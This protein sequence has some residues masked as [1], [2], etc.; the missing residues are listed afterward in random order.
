M[1]SNNIEINKKTYILEDKVLGEGA[2]GVVYKARDRNGD[3]VA[4]KKIPKNKFLVE[5]KTFLEFFKDDCDVIVCFKDFEEKTDYVY[6]VME[7]IEGEELNSSHVKDIGI[8]KLFKTLVNILNK[9][10]KKDIYHLDIKPANILVNKKTKEI[11]LADFGLACSRDKTK[12]KACGTPGYIAHEV[13][14]DVKLSCKAD[15]FSMGATLY[16]LLTGKILYKDWRSYGKNPYPYY[17]K[18]VENI[19]N[20]DDKYFEYSIILIDMI[21]IHPAD[22]P[23]PLKLFELLDI[24]DKEITKKEKD[25]VEYIEFYIDDFD[26]DFFDSKKE[27]IEELLENYKKTRKIKE[28]NKED[29][30]RIEKGYDIKL[31]N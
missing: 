4:I 5:E 28:I 2:F 13:L 12:K 6:I 29:I 21:A 17:D 25:I 11:K 8:A 20:I 15:V 16:N 7:Y 24:P 31:S 27:Y 10:C 9:L 14:K 1:E 18:A 19:F 23:T 26:E 30:K 3:F 22:R